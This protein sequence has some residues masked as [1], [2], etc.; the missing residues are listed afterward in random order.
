[1]KKIDLKEMQKYEAEKISD[2]LAKK[3]KQESAKKGVDLVK[4]T[5]TLVGRRL[6]KIKAS[7]SEE[8]GEE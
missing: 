6:Q 5:K 2:I 7:A 3:P 1:M 4:L 8:L